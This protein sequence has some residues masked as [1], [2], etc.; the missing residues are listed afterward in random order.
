[1]VVKTSN[2]QEQGKP[3]C[4]G[5]C[6][7][8]AHITFV[9]VPSVKA[10]HMTKFRVIVHWEEWVI[11]DSAV[12]ADPLTSASEISVFSDTSSCQGVKICLLSGNPRMI[13]LGQ[14]AGAI[15]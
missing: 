12:S 6:E 11:V 9:N 15:R 3:Q 14:W 2:Q 8:S 10:S 1:M 5:T 13:P 7:T 4:T